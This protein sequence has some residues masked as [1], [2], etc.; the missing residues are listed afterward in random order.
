MYIYINI[1]IEHVFL[2][3]KRGPA[4]VTLM[5]PWRGAAHRVHLW[6]WL[7]KWEHRHKMIKLCG[8][9]T[10]VVVDWLLGVL[11]G[12][13]HCY[14]S[15]RFQIFWLL[16]FGMCDQHLL[17]IV[18]LYYYF[19]CFRSLDYVNVWLLVLRF[20]VLGLGFLVS[21]SSWFCSWFWFR[22][23]VVLGLVLGLVFGFGRFLV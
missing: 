2:R 23:Q 19:S 20:L 4:R 21:G 8:P 17:A 7:Y 14:A 18:V 1:H 13:V 9:K 12:T 10:Y 15:I 3:Y 6:M 5:S 22:F 16:I 11:C